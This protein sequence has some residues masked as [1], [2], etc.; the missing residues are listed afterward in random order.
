MA[1]AARMPMIATTIMSS[2]SK[3]PSRRPTIRIRAEVA[4]SVD[5]LRTHVQTY[6]MVNDTYLPL[7]QHLSD[8][9]GRDG[10]RGREPLLISGAA[11]VALSR[12]Q[13]LALV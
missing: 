13:E 6:E 2:T 11:R 9:P 10:R 7:P 1:M 3:H 12:R 5:G 4:P 8:T